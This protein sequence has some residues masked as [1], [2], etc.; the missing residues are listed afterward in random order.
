LSRAVS[1]RLYAEKVSDEAWRE[2]EQQTAWPSRS[3]PTLQ[4]P[5]FVSVSTASTTAMKAI[6]YT[7]YAPT[8]APKRS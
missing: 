4:L 7:S 5:G 1:T 2:R 8:V 6:M 3:A